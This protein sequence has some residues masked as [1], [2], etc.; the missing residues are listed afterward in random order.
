VPELDVAVEAALGAGA[1]G[2]RMTE[3]GFGGCVLALVA[4]GGEERVR[5]AVR[6]AYAEHGFDRP[7]FFAV[8]PSAGPIG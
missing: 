8:V 3:S 6:R 2:A 7:G 1:L 4:A 5:E